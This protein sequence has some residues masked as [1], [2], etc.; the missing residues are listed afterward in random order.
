[1]N[2]LIASNHRNELWTLTRDHNSYTVPRTRS[3]EPVATLR[4]L[5]TKCKDQKDQRTG[6]EFYE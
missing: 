5:L 4:R 2:N 6:I 1:M 3:N